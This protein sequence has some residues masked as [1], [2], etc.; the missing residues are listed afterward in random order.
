M[1]RVAACCLA[2]ALCGPAAG[3]L[4]GTVSQVDLKICFVTFPPC[5]V[6]LFDEDAIEGK[7][8]VFHS[9]D[10]TRIQVPNKETVRFALYYPRYSENLEFRVAVPQ[11]NLNQARNTGRFPDTLIYFLPL[12]FAQYADYIVRHFWWLFLLVGGSLA[13]AVRALWVRLR[14]V[15]ETIIVPLA[16][17][18]V[19]SMPDELGRYRI[20]RQ[21]GS[22]GFG[23]VYAAK[24]DEG[25]PV[26]LKVL[27]GELQQDPQ[28]VKR[29]FREIQILKSL[30]HPNIVHIYDWGEIEGKTYLAMELL[31]GESLAQIMQRQPKLRRDQILHLL[32]Q[33]AGAL[34][35]LHAQGLVHR[36]IKPD[37]LFLQKGRLKVMDFGTTLSN[38][39]TRATE[40]G[41]ALGTPAF[42]SPEQIKG[43]LHPNTD[44]Y[45]LG[46]MLF[47]CL[48]GRRPFETNDPVALAYAHVHQPAPKVSPLAP[49]YGPAV[50]LVLGRM[51][52]KNP[53]ERYPS[54]SEAMRALAAA[55]QGARGGGATDDATRATPIQPGP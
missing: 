24:D 33:L 46:V 28:A 45:A 34:D 8:V 9:G 26:A 51:L 36:D 6:V 27:R 48:T 15:G 37:N 1:K 7:P 31:E 3:Q 54:V 55:L 32:P 39:L 19:A 17:E 40:T 52:A 30:Q 49:E 41:M 35:A 42:M 25:K 10:M 21:L 2:L 13:V 16:T 38:D 4:P 44:Q 5:D 50:D 29:F 43:Q 53:L 14:R 22:G 47:Q 18:S 20:E 11:V 23:E 12:S